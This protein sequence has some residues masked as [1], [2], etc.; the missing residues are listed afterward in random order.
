MEV[1]STET[2]MSPN[3]ANAHTSGAG[4]YKIMTKKVSVK[5]FTAPLEF[6]YPTAVA[7]NP[8]NIHQDFPWCNSASNKTEVPVIYA[9]EF[10][11]TWGQTMT[12]L[13][14]FLQ[15]ADQVAHEKYTDP[16]LTM[17]SAKET[18]FNYCFPH[19][20]K[21]GSELRSISNTWGNDDSFLKLPEL[22]LGKILPYGKEVANFLKGAG[23]VA[24]DVLPGFGLESTEKFTKT[25]NQT[26][27]VS[28]PLYNTKDTKTA[29][30]NYCFCLLFAFQNLKTRTSF[31]TYIPP[32]LYTLSNP[33]GGGLYMPVAVVESFN[34]ASIGTTRSLSDH[35]RDGLT[36]NRILIPE[37]YKVTIK[38]RE[39]VSPSA[40][41]LLGAMGG[42]KVSV[43]GDVDLVG[44]VN[45]VVNGALA[46]GGD[47]AS[48]IFGKVGTNGTFL[49][50]GQQIGVDL[51]NKGVDL[52]AGTFPS[53]FK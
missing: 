6:E 46:L 14:R 4:L 39:L 7:T 19:L 21:G 26:V 53:L 5:L 9:K 30:K 27:E 32:K 43:I 40:N 37:A 31:M 47:F 33:Y 36:D 17:Y 18:G 50:S 2:Q 16:Y 3:Q 28:F 44:I 20:L 15:G 1:L 38:F 29:F 35:W 22:A 34:I 48:G 41:I 23:Q 49:A 51:A 42:K 8:I 10:E 11:L 25:T 13:Q 12:N 24:G 52:A 45:G